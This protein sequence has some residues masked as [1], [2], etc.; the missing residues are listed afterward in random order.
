M[1]PRVRRPVTYALIGVLVLLNIVLIVL[2]LLRDPASASGEAGEYVPPS[3]GTSPEES[4]SGSGVE[5]DGPDESASETPGETAEAPSESESDGPVE[6]ALPVPAERLLAS[7]NG[8]VAWRAVVGD[9]QNP[10]T[11]ELTTDGGATWS[12]TDTGLAPV[13]RLKAITPTAVFAVGGVDPDCAPVYAGSVDGGNNWEQAPELVDGTWYIDP[14]DRAVLGTTV[15]EVEAPCEVAGLAGFDDAS[16]ALLCTDGS[17]S[18]ST[19]GGSSWTTTAEETGAVAVGLTLQGYVLAGSAEGCEGT[20]L[21]TAGV[22]G[23]TAPVGCAEGAEPAAGQTAVAGAGDA[24][25]LWAGEETLV[26]NDGGASW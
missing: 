5:G 24:M 9:C 25:W 15:G 26:S 19:D 11:V 23:S 6:A 14:S 21:W 10:G 17:L 1:S 8:E 2:L 18:V 4:S 3:V 7:A 20:Q 12:P 13:T 22:E 16:A